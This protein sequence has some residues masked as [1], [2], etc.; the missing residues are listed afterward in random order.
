MIRIRPAEERGHTRISW[1][2]S[3]HTFAFGGYVDPAHLGFRSLRVINEDRVAPGQGFAT[4]GHRDMEIVTVVLEGVLAHRDSLGT[5]SEIRPGEVQRMSA[6]TGITHSEF[7]ASG[8][9]PVHFLQIWIQPEQLGIAP[10]Y[11]QLAFPERER[12]GKLRVVA[13]RDGRDGSLRV[14][15][16]ASIHAGL[17]ER[18]DQLTFPLAAGRHAWLQVARGAVALNGEELATGDGAALSDVREL[19]LS[20]REASELLVFELG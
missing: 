20:A 18:G 16:D 4:H 1:L 6:G 13:S 9:E 5:G 8:S 15:Q 14:H 3:W 19:Q 7:N 10:S 11:E 2:D 12:R 17:L